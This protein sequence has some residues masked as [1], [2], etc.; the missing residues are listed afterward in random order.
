MSLS[1]R[2]A[3]H[4]EMTDKRL[5][6]LLTPDSHNGRY[7]CS[8]RL[9]AAMRYAVLGGGKRLRAF[10]VLQFCLANGGSAEDA[11]DYACAIEM[12]HAFSLVH[13][14]LPAMD[15]DDMRRGKPSTHR[16]YGEATAI[17]AGDALAIDAFRVIA[18]N[19]KCTSA[20]NAE[21]ANCLARL[22]GGYGMCGGQ[23]LDLDGEGKT[24]D[25]AA[26]SLLVER[27]TCDLMSA[28]CCLGAVAA[29]KKQLTRDERATAL[30]FGTELGFAFQI[31][32]DLLDIHSTPEKLGKTVGKDEKEQ[33]STFVSLLGEDGARKKAEDCIKD[34]K[35]W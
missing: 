27:K 11:L 1:E 34:A 23:Q 2:L 4:A 21:A 6:E 31:T 20:Q 7:N 25:E 17:L 14:D 3:L 10:L 29:T 5:K 19:G 12:V 15:D 16:K 24:L 8:P 9:F 13:D 30:T 35:L 32:D 26:V 33:K 22:A 18:D 28:A